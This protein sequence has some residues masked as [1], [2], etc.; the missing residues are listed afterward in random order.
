MTKFTKVVTRISISFALFIVFDG[1]VINVQD[2][3]DISQLRGCTSFTGTISIIGTKLISLSIPKIQAL[4]G[5]FTVQYNQYLTSFSLPDLKSAS[6]LIFTQ[7]KVL[8]AINVP[9]LKA[10]TTFNINS[11]PRLRA[12]SFPVGLNSIE[13]FEIADTAIE[14]VKGVVASRVSSLGLL[15]NVNMRSLALP[16]LLSAESL[17][18]IGNGRGNFQFEAISLSLLGQG[19]FKNLVSTYFPSLDKVTSSLTYMENSF[20][21]LSL[22]KLSEIGGTLTI[23]SNPRLETV[24]LPE[25]SHIDEDLIIENN[26]NLVKIDGFDKLYQI[27]GKAEISGDI[28]T[29]L[30]PS[31]EVVGR[32]AN[33]ESSSSSVGCNGFDNLRVGDVKVNKIDCSLDADKKD[34]SDVQETIT[35]SDDHHSKPANSSIIFD[36]QEPATDQKQEHTNTNS[37][38]KQQQNIYIANM[39]GADKINLFGQVKGHK[40]LSPIWAFEEFHM[41]MESEDN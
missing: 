33:V 10:V 17:E 25:L 21:S 27:D 15:R 28:S 1:G 41:L 2:Q 3:S 22:P 32:G 23:S 6:N 7:N 4:Q 9:R 13:N 11:A 39:N 38:V 14:L 18:I 26:Q 19:N 8:S 20:T 37:E 40:L 24:S 36:T 16:D 5:T 35:K 31:L 29:A 30:F 12:L 34:Y